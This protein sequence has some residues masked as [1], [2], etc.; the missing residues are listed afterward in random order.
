MVD[1]SPE[2]SSSSSQQ[3]G[4]VAAPP[5]PGPS[6]INNKPTET[7]A[8]LSQL[9][10]R[11]SRRRS[12]SSLPPGSPSSLD[13]LD[14]RFKRWKDAVAQRM[15]K[16]KAK[17][18]EQPELLVSVFDGATESPSTS[19]GKGSLLVDTDLDRDVRAVRA[20]IEAGLLPK[21]IQTGSSGSYFCRCREETSGSTKTCGVFKPWDEEPYGNLNPKRAFLR[22]Y[23]AW[24]MG[25]PCLIPGFSA[26]SEAGASILDEALG[27]GIV[28]PTKLVK[29]SSPSF[30]YAY[31]DRLK[32]DKEGVKLPEKVSSYNAVP[33]TAYV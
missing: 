33:A 7:T 1:E 16:G 15:G 32:Y 27:L 5:N 21:M 17:E 10:R 19:S 4:R 18:K 26:M 29:L 28:P 9:S 12:I 23:F 3:Q 11:H 31:K 6:I 20:A 13:D 25:R 22:K 30:H 14:S 8:L 24:A 2:A